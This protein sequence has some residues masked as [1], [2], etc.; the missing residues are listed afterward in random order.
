MG[1]YMDWFK[2]GM[3]T[4]IPR[5]VLYLLFVL[6]LG[7][8]L[9]ALVPAVGQ[10]VVS[11]FLPSSAGVMSD[12]IV[13]QLSGVGGFLAGLLFGAGV[14]IGIL[15]VMACAGV[16]FVVGYIIY[17]EQTTIRPKT[18]LWEY[19]TIA[20]FGILAFIFIG[21]L[22][23]ALWFLLVCTTMPSLCTG[24]SLG[25]TLLLAVAMLVVYVPLEIAYIV[26]ARAIYKWQNWSLPKPS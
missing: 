16:M 9:V 2:F 13:G 24:T 3:V 23:N 25:I 5:L 12:T 14:V 22:L 26:I 7:S 11:Q 1:S 20:F 4:A 8:V 17:N 10:S 18:E 6:L 21:A 15:A 19:I